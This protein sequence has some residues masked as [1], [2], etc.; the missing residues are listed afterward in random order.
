MSKRLKNGSLI[1]TAIASLMALMVMLATPAFADSQGKGKGQGTEKKAESAAVTEE[2]VEGD[3]PGKSDH[4]QGNAG[5]SGDPN[6]PQP[7]SNADFTGNG[8]NDDGPYDS[9]RDG[10]PSGNGN[11]GGSATGKPCAGCVG[12]ADN[13]NPPGQMPGGSDPNNGYE[14]DGNSGIGK[15]NPAHT[16]CTE[17]PPPPPCDPEVDDCGGEPPVCDPTVE[18]CDPGDVDGGIITDPPE[19]DVQGTR[20]HRG[21]NT[22]PRVLGTR[23]N[24]GG[25]LPFTGTGSVV[26]YLA[27]S[28]ILVLSGGLLWRLNRN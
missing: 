2:V 25:A 8:A 23:F 22:G 4:S 26:M 20:T 24:R 9:T 28:M 19:D 10:S 3:A 1:A 13:K 14:C 16:G 5:T 11:G 7:G 27:L 6:E 17:S 21:D 18:D 12:K 15:T